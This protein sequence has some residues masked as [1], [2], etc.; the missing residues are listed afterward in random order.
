MTKETLL[1]ELSVAIA[2]TCGIRVHDIKLYP[3]GYGTHVEEL[4]LEH[5][6]RAIKN[7]ITMVHI[8]ILGRMYL[9]GK[10]ACEYDLTLPFESQSVE[11]LQFLYDI[12]YK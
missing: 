3:E 2:K 7:T 11:T 8:D 1:E 5:V 12:I 10:Y 6:L 9:H 4:H